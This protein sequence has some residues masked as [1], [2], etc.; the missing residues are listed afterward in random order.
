MTHPEQQQAG[1][2][3]KCLDAPEVVGCIVKLVHGPSAE[4]VELR[5]RIHDSEKGDYEQCW[6][7]IGGEWYLVAC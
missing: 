6:V 7:K 4:L 3:I 2:E 5:G 1:Q